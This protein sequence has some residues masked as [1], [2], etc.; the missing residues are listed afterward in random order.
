MTN[1]EYCAIYRELRPLALAQTCVA[2][3][4]SPCRVG[5]QAGRPVVDVLCTP[6]FESA[7]YAFKVTSAQDVHREYVTA[8]AHPKMAVRAALVRARKELA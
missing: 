5:E 3:K 8:G 1:A 4:R 6:C 2:C 7:P